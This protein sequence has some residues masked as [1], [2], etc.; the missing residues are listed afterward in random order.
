[1]AFKILK[2]IRMIW[3]MESV[4]PVKNQDNLKNQKSADAMF[5]SKQN[6]MR[7]LNIML[8]KKYFR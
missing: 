1:M 2:K 8:M 6:P 4:K 7:S 5:W 3:M